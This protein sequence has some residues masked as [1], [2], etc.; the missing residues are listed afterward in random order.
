VAFSEKGCRDRK[1]R[2]PRGLKLGAGAKGWRIDA[3]GRT[4]FDGFRVAGGH[5]SLTLAPGEMVLVA[6]PSADAPRPANVP[7]LMRTFTGKDLGG[8]EEWEKVSALELLERFRQDGRRPAAAFP[9]A[10]E[11]QQCGSISYHLRKGRHFLALYDWD[12]Y[13]DFAERGGLAPWTE[14]K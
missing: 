14:N 13:M 7:P 10:G 12:R 5:V 4:P 2:I 11:V 3:R 6:E 9:R 1:W 8:V